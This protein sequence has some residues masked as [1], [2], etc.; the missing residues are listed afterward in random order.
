MRRVIS[1][2]TLLTVMF[3]AVGVL[4]STSPEPV[5]SSTPEVSE[6]PGPFPRTSHN[7]GEER[8]EEVRKSP[9]AT[10]LPPQSNG[11]KKEQKKAEKAA[12]D[13]R[14]KACK[15]IFKEAVKAHEAAIKKAKQDLSA[16]NK[17][18]RQNYLTATKK[19]RDDWKASDKGA[20]A[21]QAYE[22]AK[23]AAQ[24][25]FGAAKK[26]AQDAF[27]TTRLN[28]RTALDTATATYKQCVRQNPTPTAT[29]N[30]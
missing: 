26:T 5:V 6:V 16:S 22:S 17:S 8:R 10:Q 14:M 1:T 23:K 25:T 2:A 19:A 3:L 30:P 24:D 20:A 13:A 4:A 27:T 21:K 12:R 28:A 9:G 7:P 15:A 29:V 11:N 18:A